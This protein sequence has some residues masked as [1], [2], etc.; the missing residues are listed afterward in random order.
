MYE[1]LQAAR[2]WATTR[3]GRPNPPRAHLAFVPIP[4]PPPHKGPVKLLQRDGFLEIS[5]EDDRK[6]SPSGW[7]RVGQ[8]ERAA[9]GARLV[10]PASAFPGFKGGSTRGHTPLDSYVPPPPPPSSSH[11][12]EDT[13]QLTALRASQPHTLSS[14]RARY[15][16]QTGCAPPRTYGEFFVFARERGCLVD[17]RAY[18]GVFA[19][20]APFWGVERA[21]AGLNGVEA[22]EGSSDK[23]RLAVTTD[24]RG[25]TALQIHCGKVV[26]LDYQGTYFGGDWEA[27]VNK[28][29]VVLDIKPSSR[30]LMPRPPPPTDPFALVPPSTAAFFSARTGC[31][32][33]ASA[34]GAL[35]SDAP[36][37]A[38]G[39]ARRR[40]R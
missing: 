37:S 25:M 39:A 5:A 9:R 23:L 21:G 16:L 17:A 8:R 38:G 10:R 19:D 26:R 24:K 4:L 1:A 22:K 34:N 6:E 29:C 33:F 7:R 18:G 32:G 30:F 14:V 40:E 28:S 27:T 15:S 3:N 31:G 35:D 36:S 11:G 2:K 20:F 13:P 12:S